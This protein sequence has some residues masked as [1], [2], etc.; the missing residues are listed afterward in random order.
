MRLYGHRWNIETCFNQLKTHAK[1]NALKCQTRD[2]VIKELIMYLIVWNLVRL[3][4]IRFARRAD[5]SVWR[6]S[7]VDAVRWLSAL[8][9]AVPPTQLQLLINPDRPNRWEP[10]LLKRRLKLY[11]MLNEP[12]QNLKSKHR[13]RYG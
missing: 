4:M 9:A 1:M 8:L 3:A 13:A 2:G 11:D 5:V 6:V 7:F 10:R 12:R